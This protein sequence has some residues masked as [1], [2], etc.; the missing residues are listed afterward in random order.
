MGSAL[1]TEERVDRTALEE[2]LRALPAR[3]GSTC[4]GT[5]TGR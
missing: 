1:G 4:S 3:P 5:P 2:K